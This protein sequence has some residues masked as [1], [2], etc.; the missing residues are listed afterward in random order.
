MLLSLLRQTEVS[1]VLSEQGLAEAIPDHVGR[2]VSGRM[3][4]EGLRESMRFEGDTDRA[5][6]RRLWQEMTDFWREP[7]AA[8]L[9]R[10]NDGFFRCGDWRT[11]LLEIELEQRGGLL[12]SILHCCKGLKQ[13]GL[14]DEQLTATILRRHIDHLAQESGLPEAEAQ[15]I[16]L[17]PE[18]KARWNEEVRRIARA[19]ASEV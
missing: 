18:A 2:Y 4:A 1:H 15:R 9:N 7:G 8:A 16:G 13:Q 19:C 11:G 6:A 5:A 14:L 17:S 12:V 3:P 10:V